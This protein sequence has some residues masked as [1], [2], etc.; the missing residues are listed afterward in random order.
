VVNGE[1]TEGGTRSVDV[2]F[3][4]ELPDDLAPE[5]VFKISIPNTELALQLDE[6]GDVEQPPCPETLCFGRYYELNTDT[7]TCDC[8]LADQERPC[9]DDAT[10]DKAS[11]ACVISR[12]CEEVITCSNEETWLAWPACKCYCQALN[13]EGSLI[14]EAPKMMNF[15]TCTCEDETTACELTAEDCKNE[16]IFDS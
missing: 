7:C 4:F 10:L 8:T 12:E 1:T 15:E 6:D 13:E 2:N 16:E 3:H 11:C 14:C 5:E 9:P